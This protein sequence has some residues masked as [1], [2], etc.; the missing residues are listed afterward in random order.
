MK[1][2]MSG[3]QRQASLLPID[4]EPSSAAASQTPQQASYTSCLLSLCPSSH[5]E[6]TDSPKTLTAGGRGERLRTG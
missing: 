6:S 4:P 3:G 1:A 2:D 5:S